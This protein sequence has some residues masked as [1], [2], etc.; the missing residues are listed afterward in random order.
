[1]VR[2]GVAWHGFHGKAGRGEVWPGLVRQGM[3][4]MEKFMK[5]VRFI[6]GRLATRPGANHPSPSHWEALRQER[7][8]VQRGS[9]GEVYCGTCWRTE[10]QHGGFDL[11]H[12]HYDSFGQEAV[13]DVILICRSCHD[14]ITSRIRGERYALGDRS[15]EV[16]E[17]V[18]PEIHRPTIQRITVEIEATV[19]QEV[20]RFRPNMR[21]GAV[22]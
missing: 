17:T 2:S 8:E 20:P 15:L 5:I 6:D 1:M 11:H 14:A 3:G 7:R 22:Y 21:R 9:T 12:R 19:D 10:A 13:E 18:T 16:V 4:F